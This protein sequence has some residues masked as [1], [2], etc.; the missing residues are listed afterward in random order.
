MHPT[1]DIMKIL[2][3]K[4][5]TRKVH[6]TIITQN[7]SSEKTEIAF[8]KAFKAL[9]LAELLWSVIIK[10]QSQTTRK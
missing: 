9:K 6:T 7:S 3:N 4:N 5:Q 2:T 10:V 8:L 1:S